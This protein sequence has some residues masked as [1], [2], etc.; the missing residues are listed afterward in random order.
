VRLLLQDLRWTDGG[1]DRTGC[2]RIRGRTIAEIGRGLA[3]RRRE[4]T[5]ALSGHLVF[6][7]LINAH[8]HLGLNLLP[9]LGDPPYPSL[10]AFGEDVF[11]PERSPIREHLQVPVPDRLWWGGYKNLVSGAT[12]AVHHDPFTRRVF[13]RS[14]PVRVPRRYGWSH[15]LGYGKDL[16]G[17]FAASRGWP[18][19]VHAAEGV[20]EA[21]FAEIDRLDEL[22]VLGPRTVLVHA[23]ALTAAQHRRVAD[24]GAAV[25]WCP[26]SNL[27]LYG[28]TAAVGELRAL[29]V[30]VAL[31]TDS[32]LTG[33]PTLLDEMRAGLDTGLASA[34]EIVAMVTAGAARIFGLDDRGRVAEGLA[35]DLVVLPDSGGRPADALLAATPADLT[36]VV[37]GG[38]VRSAAAEPA[39]I[40]ELGEPDAAVDGR[41]RWLYGDVGA[42][43]RRILEASAP[44]TPEENPLWS[45]IG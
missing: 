30:D 37:V 43:K 38:D 24:A 28:R 1:R 19:I 13:R 44:W 7:G 5:L 45:R 36:L 42:L 32:T 29:G 6:P 16:P 14:F 8:D 39:E 27:R 4:R 21:S 33:S 23:V 10:Y 11:R 17:A 40:L 15:S 12:T 3:P 35:A 41:E 26:A 20:D 31:G 18:F 25:V 9:H 22:G 2:L 34:D